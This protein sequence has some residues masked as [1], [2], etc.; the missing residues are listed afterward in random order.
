MQKSLFKVL[1]NLVVTAHCCGCVPFV[2]ASAAVHVLWHGHKEQ[3]SVLV[4]L[5]LKFKY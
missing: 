1:L 2:N 3:M 5:S 4:A